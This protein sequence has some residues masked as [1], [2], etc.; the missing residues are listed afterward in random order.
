V[1]ALSNDDVWAVG[2]IYSDSGE[3]NA[4]HWDGND[5]QLFNI[6]VEYLG[7]LVSP[8]MNGIYG[9]SSNDVWSTTGSPWHWDGSSWM[10]FH[11]WDMG[12]LAQEDG[13]VPHIWGTSSSNIYFAGSKG[14]L[15]HYDGSNWL[16]LDSGT[17]L[18]L[19]DIIGF[20]DDNYCII[21]SSLDQQK[22]ELLIYQN[23]QLIRK[24]QDSQFIKGSLWGSNPDDLYVVGEGLFHF[25]GDSLKR[26]DWPSGTPSY[27]MSAIR[28]SAANN[29]FVVGSFCT[30]L[31]FNGST[32]HYYPQLVL[33]EACFGVSLTQNEVFIVG[34]GGIIYH[35]IK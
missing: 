6:E 32:W 34:T 14:S 27:F 28:G 13:G 33:S 21:A 35:G 29:L 17:D 9:F 31:H 22:Y 11:L 8:P 1:F 26:L 15:V 3:Y 23:K 25:N 5:W 18:N 10:F 12:I 30:V 4:V 7:H 24:I 2:E 20:T 16:K 19:T